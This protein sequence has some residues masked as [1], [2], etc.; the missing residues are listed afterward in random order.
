[1]V[2][3]KGVIEVGEVSKGTSKFGDLG[4]NLSVWVAGLEHYCDNGQGLE[5]LG[6][7]RWLSEADA[8][9]DWCGLKQ[10]LPILTQEVH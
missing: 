3:S 4:V 9:T 1:M 6:L 10:E 2:W 7:I 5:R 8:Y